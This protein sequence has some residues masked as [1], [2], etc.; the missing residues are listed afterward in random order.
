MARNRAYEPKSLSGKAKWVIFISVALV[1][2]A[3][4]IVLAYFLGWLKPPQA[5]TPGETTANTAVG[6]DVVIHFVAG[7]DLNI[8]DKVI[9]SG[10]TE[11]GYDFS[12]LFL[13]VM[14]V[15]SGGDLTVLNFEGNL[16][17]EP[18]GSLHNSAPKALVTA[19]QKAGVDILQTA[20]SK[21]VTN[22]ILGLNAT[23]QAIRD[24]KLQ[25]VGTYADTAEFE[26]Y[27]GFIIREVQGIR[28]AITAFTKG[29]DGRGL[30]L[31]SESC[32]NLLYTDY[33]STYQKV[34]EE[35]IRSVL[36]DI[37]AQKPD[38]TIALLHWG[39]EFNDQISSSQ[40]TIC[41][42]MAA[43]GVDAIIGTHPHYV[44][45][46]DYYKDT[47]MFVA[48]SL[49]DFCGDGDKAG[50]NYS[51]LLDLEIT[52][53]GATGQVW[54]TDYSYTPVFLYENQ[55]GVVRLLRIREAMAA[56]ENSALDAVP[57]EIYDKMAA[58]LKR[59]EARVNGS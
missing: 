52:R 41:D 16:Y 48:Y 23:L 59:I 8:T 47:G 40:N 7:G 39:S 37:A 12:E 29:M 20:N 42:L 26:K 45:E 30:P 31:G 28:I 22:G 36:S 49:G 54:I 6:E 57:K 18:Y 5:Q 17:G 44:Q 21:S 24:A 13:D 51:V 32:V 43:G 9:A 46:M 55:E 56:Y 14:P 19:L 4:L 15:L 35:G 53:D 1:L 58:A 10:A 25:P 27:Q 34:D 11:G 50:T 3:G 38:L 33:N 2:L